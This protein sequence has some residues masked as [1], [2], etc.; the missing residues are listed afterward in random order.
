MMPLSSNR[1]PAS[2]IRDAVLLVL[3][4]LCV[5]CLSVPSPAGA[6]EKMSRAQRKELRKEQKEAIAKLP[7]KYQE[8]IAEIELLLTEEELTSFLAL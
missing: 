3:T 5:L 7:A 6:A 8:W 4:V 2:S 1:S